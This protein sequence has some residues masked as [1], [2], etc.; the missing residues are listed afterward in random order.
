MLTKAKLL[1]FIKERNKSPFH[2]NLQFQ[3][4]ANACGF[5]VD[6]LGPCTKV[7]TGHYYWDTPAGLLVEIGQTM[8]LED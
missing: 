3:I 7:A 6:D 8:K 5:S 4:D 1:R 2:S